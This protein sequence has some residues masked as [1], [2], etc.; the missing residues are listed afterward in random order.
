MVQ[1]VSAV[2]L[3]VLLVFSHFYLHERLRPSEWAAAG[4][5]TAGVLGLGASAEPG[6]GDMPGED[7]SRRLC[8]FVVLLFCTW[9]ALCSVWS[10][11]RVGARGSLGV[12][13]RFGVV[14]GGAGG[15]SW[16]SC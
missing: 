6:H 14:E 4:V 13:P 10:S 15:S 3:V 16:A 7:R 5:A 8:R 1:P 2:G 9:T 11:V 12:R